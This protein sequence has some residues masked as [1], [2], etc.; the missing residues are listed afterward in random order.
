MDCEMID[1]ENSLNAMHFDEQEIE[2]MHYL[3][4]YLAQVLKSNFAFLKNKNKI[5]KSVFRFYQERCMKIIA[6]MMTKQT[7]FWTALI[8]SKVKF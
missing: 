1:I 3:Y 7:L 6:N 2:Q 5:L 8:I 4:S